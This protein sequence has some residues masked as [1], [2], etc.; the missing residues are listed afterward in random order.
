MSSRQ[1]SRKRR[2]KASTSASR[3]YLSDEI[4][5][6]DV[7]GAYYDKKF[8]GY[9]T[10]TAR[11]NSYNPVNGLYECKYVDGYTE[12]LSRT[13]LKKYGLFTPK[14]DTAVLD[15]DMN[16]DEHPLLY[17]RKRARKDDQSA[18]INFDCTNEITVC[19]NRVVVGSQYKVLSEGSAWVTGTVTNIGTDGATT[20]SYDSCYPVSTFSKEEFVQEVSTLLQSNHLRW[21]NGNDDAQGGV[22]SVTNSSP[23]RT[24]RPHTNE[25]LLSDSD[26]EGGDCMPMH[27]VAEMDEHVIVISDSS[28]SDNDEESRLPSTASTINRKKVVHQW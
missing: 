3:K 10:W 14:K 23:Q 12:T 19:G 13:Q 9:G 25:I 17:V 27:T 22:N 28:E 5:G 7:V 16:P 2:Y 6:E 24:L 18:D 8:V 21:P 1:P 20:V 15:P 26:E 4:V 11:V